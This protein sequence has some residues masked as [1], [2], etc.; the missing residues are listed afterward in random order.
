MIDPCK[1]KQKIKKKVFRMNF[2]QYSN[3]E[4]TLTNLQEIYLEINAKQGVKI[5][6]QGSNVYFNKIAKK[7]PTTTTESLQKSI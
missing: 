2:L 1:I 7:V 4:E 6:K 5:L 3:S